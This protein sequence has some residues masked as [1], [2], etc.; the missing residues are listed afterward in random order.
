MKKLVFFI[1]CLLSVFSYQYCIGQG[2]KWANPLPQ[3]NNLNSVFF[4]D[5]M[6][7]WAVGDYGT[8]VKYE[9]EK[10]MDLPK[11]TT[12]N[13]HSVHFI[14]QDFGYIVGDSGIILKYNGNKWI[15]QYSPTS[16]DLKSIFIVDENNAW[17]AGGNL[18]NNKGGIIL[19][20]DGI[21]WEVQLH[22]L[23]NYLNSIYFTSPTNGFAVGT[24]DPDNGF[25][26][27]Y[28]GKS[29]TEQYTSV[30][31]NIF[32]T[33]CFTDSIHGW[34]SGNNGILNYDGMQWSEQGI[35]GDVT[36]IC[37]P[38]TNHGWV[39]G[40]KII[41]SP[42]PHMLK[43]DGKQWT[44]Y[45]DSLLLDIPS[46]N[47]LNS[48]YFTDAKHGW[49]VGEFGAIVRYNGRNWISETIDQINPVAFYFTKPNQGWV[50]GNDNG[51]Y[52]SNSGIFKYDKGQWS[53]KD[54]LIN[55]YIS[56][57]YFLDS[58]HVWGGVHEAIWMYDGEKWTEQ[59]ILEKNIGPIWSIYIADSKHGWAGCDK[60]ILKYDGKQWK[61]QFNTYQILS[62]YGIDS[63]NVW[64]GKFKY[65]GIE[66]IEYDN[67]VPV[68]G[69][70]KFF[71]D[72]LHG[73]SVGYKWI[74]KY[75]GKEWINQNS[76][77]NNNLWSVYFTDTLH[78]W[79]VGDNGTILQYNGKQWKQQQSPTNYNL[80]NVYFSDSTNGWIVGDYRTLLHTTSGGEIWTDIK[81]PKVQTSN[82]K[83]QIYPNPASSLIV[84]SCP[85]IENKSVEI[86]I[87]DLLGKKILSQNTN[88]EKTQVDVSTIVDGIYFLKASSNSF[89]KTQKIIVKH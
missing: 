49:A 89:S 45:T 31:P 34:V 72:S 14:N 56:C 85:L 67:S 52:Q 18:L 10:W 62:I 74:S 61:L 75:N 8:I 82:I 19:K 36:S 71:T 35:W 2:W 84:V 50:L 4:T 46:T 13:L 5:S 42:A 32:F 3:G 86:S 28:D 57:G 33:A 43:Y 51:K 37:L 38:D 21:N 41:G 39:V 83:V 65:N 80:R 68:Y 60:G 77:T 11:I 44:D 87:Y 27:K 76:G 12:K 55:G 48:I 30:Y 15:K 47:I 70:S 54:G 58:N 23:S 26:L 69:A 1:A 22:N 25:I 78:G 81:N 16:L 20:Y 7:G 29:W 24:H 17:V 6:H 59:D 40:S 73:W 53:N 88:A 9:N 79:A 63:N 66:W 64:A